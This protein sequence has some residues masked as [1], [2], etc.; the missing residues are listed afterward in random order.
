[1]AQ[2]FA[3]ASFFLLVC[4][5]LTA[6][7][8]SRADVFLA[9]MRIVQGRTGASTARAVGPYRKRWI[10]VFQYPVVAILLAL[11][12]DVTEAAD[13]Y[14]FGSHQAYFASIWV[15]VLGKI[16]M[17]LAVFAVL[18][19]YMSLKVELHPHRALQKLFAFK[20]LIGLQFLQGVRYNQPLLPFRHR[21][22]KKLFFE[23]LEKPNA[24]L[25]WSRS[26]T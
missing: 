25:R 18:R 23:N 13:K 9:P 6:E 16:S 10:Y 12:A 7:A 21:Q 17:I 14:C 24:N 19:T 11:L 4:R 15:D 26:C 20:L 1:M 8:D 5:L 3:L 2:A 22:K